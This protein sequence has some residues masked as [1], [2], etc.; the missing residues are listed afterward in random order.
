[1]IKSLLLENLSWIRGFARTFYRNRMDAE[2]LAGETILKVLLNADKY[3]P[4]M[5]FRTWVQVIMRNTYRIRIRHVG[6]VDSQENLPDGSSASD[7]FTCTVTN[8]C[9]ATVSECVKS[10][11]GAKSAFLYAQGYS[12]NEIAEMQ[13]VTVSIVKSRVHQGRKLI[14]RML[15]G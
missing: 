9:M 15:S 4:D 1:M 8:E 14:M 7:P 10:S 3:N 6:V 12:Y 13:G 11:M 5:K 2:D